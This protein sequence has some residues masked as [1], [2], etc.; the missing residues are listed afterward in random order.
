MK[1]VQVKLYLNLRKYATPGM[2]NGQGPVSLKAGH[3]AKDLLAVL[4]IPPGE[5]CT[6]VVNSR[7]AGKDL[8]L[9]DG[10][11]VAVLPPVSGG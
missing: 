8:L 3:T 5:E 9:K 1:T 2:D 4:G 11:Q 7:I 10:D 6:L